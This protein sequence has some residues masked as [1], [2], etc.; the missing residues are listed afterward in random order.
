MNENLDVKK[1]RNVHIDMMKGIGIMLVVFAHTYSNG[2]A[3]YLFHMP[4]F[5]MLSGA[6]LVYAKHG[7]SLSR[8][9]KGIMVPYFI[10]SLLWFAYWWLIESRLRP[11]HDAPLFPGA[12]GTLNVK[13]QQ[14]VNIFVATSG[15]EAFMYNVV[16]WFLPCLFVADWLY[17]ILRKRKHS[18]AYVAVSAILYYVAFAKFPA[19]PWCFNLAVLSVSL[20]FIGHKTYG[21]L[22]QTAT[23]CGTA[24]N[25]VAAVVLT[26]VFVAIA[27]TCDL[28]VDMRCGIVP[29]FYS[30]YG[31][32]ILGSLI[33]FAVS[34]VLEK[35][36][37]VGGVISYFGRNSLIVMCIHEPLKRVLLVVLSKVTAIPVETLRGDVCL[38][39]LCTLVLM[40]V[41]VPF[42]W[43]INKR[44]P[45]MIGK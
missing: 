10:F 27:L 2:G 20:L 21:W 24:L 28:R 14:F 23:R 38:S 40:A 25:L 4:L 7:Y 31:M 9:F 1:T 8:R 42:I 33:V 26:A 15:G 32:A 41:C 22:Y 43:G 18:W 39:I 17:A 16:L 12:L 35:F 19:L 6:V 30:F 36:R 45:W 29:P 44:L 34:L 13:V 3:I 37:M 5:F 11:V